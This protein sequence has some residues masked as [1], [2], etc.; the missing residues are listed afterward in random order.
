MSTFKL[1]WR[2]DATQPGV[3][4]DDR[5][6]DHFSKVEAAAATVQDPVVETRGVL[7]LR[8]WAPPVDDQLSVSDCVTDSTTTAQELVEIR[9]GMPFVKKSRLFLYYNARLQTQDTDKDEGTYIRLAFATLTSL[10]SCAEATWPYDLN[11]VFIR[12]SWSAYQEAL[13]RKI[14]SFYRI[15]AVNG[16]ELVT[17]IKQALQAQH[18]VVFGMTVDQDYMDTGSDGMVSM[19]KANRVNTGGHAQ[20]IVGYD[21]NTMRWIV[22]NSWGTGWGDGGYA[23]V[24]Y[25]YLDAS[26]A[27]DFWVPYID[28][29]HNVPDVTT[30][31]VTH[32]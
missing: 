28:A 30:V 11:N 14:K 24:P 22:K 8:K 21:D 29:S 31:V 13:P 1:S 12:P 9:N 32:D 25:A 7:D 16:T 3:H 4:L 23:Y 17:A 27:S 15:D 10:G 5:L 18:P 26:D 2:P 6:S 19:P 20:C